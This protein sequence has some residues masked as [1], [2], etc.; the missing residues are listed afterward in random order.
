MTRPIPPADSSNIFL[1]SDPWSFESNADNPQLPDMPGCNEEFCWQN[2]TSNG[3]RLFIAVA[4]DS[5]DP[6][7]R[8]AS[9]KFTFSTGSCP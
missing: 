6:D 8:P 2:A 4:Y 1:S 7:D 5:S 3:A 9:V